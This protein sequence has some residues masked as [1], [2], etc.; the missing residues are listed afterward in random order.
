[1]LLPFEVELGTELSYELESV[2]I[3]REG[4]FSLPSTI[5]LLSIIGNSHHHYNQHDREQVGTQRMKYSACWESVCLS[6]L[7][8]SSAYHTIPY[9]QH[10]IGLLN[11][12]VPCHC[13]NT[14]SVFFFFL[15]FVPS[16]ICMSDRRITKSTICI[17]FWRVWLS[18][19]YFMKSRCARKWELG[20]KIRVAN[21]YG[22][23]VR[24][25]MDSMCYS[26]ENLS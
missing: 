16:N 4:V 23:G 11:S 1:M 19:F 18:F 25:M 15:L 26:I 17:G 24:F 3:T 9:Q 8:E 12:F 6:V 5:L 13:P 7:S 14:H 20:H 2:T 10:S 21:A 22:V